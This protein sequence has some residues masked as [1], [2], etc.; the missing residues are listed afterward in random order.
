MGPAEPSHPVACIADKDCSVWNASI[1]GVDY[2]FTCLNSICQAASLAL[3]PNDVITLCQ[4]DIPWP[5][6]CPYITS[7]PFASRMV[8]VGDL[9]GVGKSSCSA[10]PSGCKQPT[11]ATAAIDAGARAIDAGATAID[12]GASP[13]ADVDAGQ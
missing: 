12:S 6:S 2:N 11:A 1:S 9:C 5:S 3:S 8:E 10:V 7:Q 4:A 13:S